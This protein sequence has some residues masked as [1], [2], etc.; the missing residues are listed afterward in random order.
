MAQVARVMDGVLGQVRQVI[1]GKHQVLK[2]VAAGMITEGCHILFEDMPGLAK[3]VMASAVSQASGCEFRRI[4]FTPDLLPGD[5]TG[6]YIY[7]QNNAEFSLRPG[8]IFCNVLLADEINRA[9]PKTQSALLEAMAEKQVSIEGTTHRLP[10]PFMVLATQN[11]VEQEGTYPLP[12]AQL[13]RFMLK[14][15]M[16]YPSKEEEKEILMR[17]AKRG[18]DAFEVKPV[19]S[20]D[21][22]RDMMRAVEFV[23][24]SDPIYDYLTEIV[25][26]TR[27]H[28][29][30][31]A[32]SSPR[33]SLALFKLS[34]AWAAVH[35]RA[36][37][38]ADDIRDLAVPVLAH[39]L[40]LKPEARLSGRTGRD[41]CREILEQTPVP[42]FTV[43][44]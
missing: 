37:V 19:V 16:G 22:L 28:P 41:V 20:P 25:D 31:H 6:T 36:Y 7:N 32:G 21:I 4:Q 3:S 30:L 15:S 23:H 38:T 39:R 8:P 24:V 2:Y 5:I 1:V 17:R 29:D 13:D 9:S 42:K 26:R 14:L 34:R 11:P 43:P 10:A 44:A 12:E 18:K 27:R 35:G 33:G 40:I